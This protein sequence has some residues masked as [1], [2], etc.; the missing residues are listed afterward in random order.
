VRQSYVGLTLSR[1]LAALIRPLLDRAF[2]VDDL[3]LT[4]TSMEYL[5]FQVA[6][7]F[8]AAS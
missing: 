7:C 5:A 1:W 4:M 3:A 8:L 2:F 6:A